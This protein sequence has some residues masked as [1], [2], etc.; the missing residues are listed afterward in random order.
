MAKSLMSSIAVFGAT[1]P[2]G[3]EIVKAALQKSHKVTAFVRNPS[4]LEQLLPDH[5]SHPHLST[6]SGDATDKE[7][8]QK[9][10]GESSFD[11]VIITLGSNPFADAKSL[12]VCSEATRLILEALGSAKTKPRIIC[13]S[14][15][16]A[17]ESSEDMGWIG[18]FIAWAILGRVLADKNIQEDIIRKS[19]LPWLICR[20]GGLTNAPAQFKYRVGERLKGP[21]RI[22]RADVAHFCI[23]NLTDPQYVGKSVSLID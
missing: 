16:G 15:M 5:K 20:P 18:G 12:K 17:G 13:V 1:G 9:F 7:S 19:G 3:V 10:L 2:T 4:K 14:S 8:I 11:Q 6:V 21:G 22:S 23:E